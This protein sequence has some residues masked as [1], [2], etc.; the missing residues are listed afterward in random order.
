[1]R[2]TCA[3]AWHRPGGTGVPPVFLSEDHKRVEVCVPFVQTC[4]PAAPGGRA[5]RAAMPT[6]SAGVLW[7]QEIG[8]PRRPAPAGNDPAGASRSLR[9]S[10]DHRLGQREDR[11]AEPNSLLTQ[12][13]RQSANKLL[14]RLN[15]RWG[16]RLLRLRDAARNDPAKS[17]PIVHTLLF[18]MPVA[19]GASVETAS[20]QRQERFA[21]GFGH[22]SGPARESGLPPAGCFPRRS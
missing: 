12:S 1:M 21:G 9:P 4:P 14:E 7:T 2:Q 17:E 22:A 13:R 10:P 3:G 5:A 15:N 18:R 11:P 16:G 8:R 20:T 6:R 19:G